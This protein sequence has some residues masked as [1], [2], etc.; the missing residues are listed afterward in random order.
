M[1]ASSYGEKHEESKTKIKIT[2]TLKRDEMASMI[3][4]A[5]ETLIRFMAELKKEGLIEQDGKAIII[6]NRE[7][8]LDYAGIDY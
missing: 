7:K 1:L 5:P 3:G 6:V 4:T 2:I 8:L